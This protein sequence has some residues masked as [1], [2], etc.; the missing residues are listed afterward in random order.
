MQFLIPFTLIAA[1]MAAPLIEERQL[2]SDT[3][4][5]Y[6]TG[7]CKNVVML[8]ARASTET[9][10]IGSSVGPLLKSYL[11]SS[12][13]ADN[14]AMQGIDYPATLEDNFLTGGTTQAAMTTMANLITDVATKCPDAKIVAGGY[15]QGTAVAARGID[16]LSS[17]L[18]SRIDAVVLFGYTQNQQLNGGVP[19]ISSDRVKVFCAVGDLVCDGTLT[20]TLSHFTYT[21]ADAKTGADFIVSKVQ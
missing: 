6:T 13:G 8:Y 15:S 20:I 5:D 12:L 17:D 16:K 2:A 3:S 11:T 4:N 19:G 1:A 21:G 7:G 18:K 10:N 14:F 9:G